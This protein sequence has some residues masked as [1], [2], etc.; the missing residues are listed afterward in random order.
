MNLIAC[1]QTSIS[2]VLLTDH[3]YFEVSCTL[4]Y[5]AAPN[6]SKSLP[7]SL[8]AIPTLHLVLNPVSHQP[9][10]ATV[11]LYNFQLRIPTLKFGLWSLCSRST[12]VDSVVVPPPVWVWDIPNPKLWF[13]KLLWQMHK[14]WLCPSVISSTDMKNSDPGWLIMKQFLHRWPNVDYMIVSVADHQLP[15]IQKTHIHDESPKTRMTLQKNLHQRPQQSSMG[16]C[17]I[18]EGTE[19][20][21]N[22]AMDNL[23]GDQ[24]SIC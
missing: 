5:R 3:C 6:P 2:E 20:W 7:P 18:H 19:L 16:C 10:E 8:V 22:L 24:T 11:I 14:C 4:E 9:A 12:N 15:H 23:T 1:T 21:P 17:Y 13:M